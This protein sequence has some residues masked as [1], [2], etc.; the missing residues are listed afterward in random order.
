MTAALAHY[1]LQPRSGLLLAFA[2]MAALMHF[3]GR[4]RLRFARQLS[5]HS[6]F[7]APYNALV[8]LFSRVA[9]RPFLNAADFPELAAL[10]ANW[11][12]FRDE[13]QGLLDAGRIAAATGDNDIGFHS[14]FRRGWTRFYLKWYGEPLPSAERWAPRSLEILKRV[15]SI[16][17]AMFAALPPGARLGRHR[18]P[19]AGSV[20]YHLGLVTPNGD[21]CWI[22]VDGERRAW[23]NGEVMLFDETY[24]H[25][26]FNGWD[27]T[28]LVL[29]CDVERPLRQPLAALNRWIAANVMHAS[30]TQNVPGESVGA[31]NRIYEQAAKLIAA[32][33][34]LKARNPQL[35]R[36]L[37]IDAAIG[38]VAVLL[39]PW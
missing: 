5:D 11:T 13:A 1:L 25:E 9:N 30:R 37:K 23:S 18:D 8:Y 4:V 10:K 39:A 3:R 31:I 2:G 6:T 26:A 19:F 15:P 38:L 33:K 16:K 28:R 27:R 35:Y 14:F 36:M 12:T 17:G 32:G 7:T 20:R 29:F 22:E 21:R 34:A 24:V